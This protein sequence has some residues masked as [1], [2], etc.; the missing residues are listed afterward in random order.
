MNHTEPP[1]HM[2]LP[3][4]RLGKTEGLRG[5]NPTVSSKRMVQ[6]QLCPQT[7]Q[8]RPDCVLRQHGPDPTVSSGWS[9]PGGVLRTAQTRPYPQDG[10]DPTVSSEWPRHSRVLRQ[11]NPDPTVS[12]DSAAQTRPC[13]Q[14]GWPRPDRALRRDCPDPVVTSGWPRPDHVLRQDGPDPTM[15][16]GWPRP[17]RGLR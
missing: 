7:G 15:S 11:R 12:S 16:S 14:T 3:G 9:R 1:L 2:I 17:D 13:P 10:P 5:P 6:I 4:H 8:S